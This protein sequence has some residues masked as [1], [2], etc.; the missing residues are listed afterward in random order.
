MYIPQNVYHYS[1]SSEYA[2]HTPRRVHFFGHFQLFWHKQSLC[3][4]IWRR[5]K[6][7]ILLQWFLLN[8][9]KL[10]SAEQLTDLFWNDM[11]EEAATRNLHV[12]IHYLRHLLEPDLP[13]RQ[14]STFLRRN[15]NNFYWFELDDTWWADIFDVH[16]LYTMAIK[17]DQEH[18]ASKAIFR[19]QK[20]VNYCSRG[21]LPGDCSEA[22]FSAHRNQYDS[23]Y[24]QSLVRLIQLFLER[25]ELEEVME[26]AYQALNLDHCCE[27][28]VKAIA[29]VHYQQK[30]YKEALS[31][32]DDFQ[33]QLRREF[34]VGPSQGIHKLREEM[35]Q[36][37][38]SMHALL[39][40]C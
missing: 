16:H 10:Y 9:G 31:R 36:R 26:Y 24:Y 22:A 2:Y 3:K 29:L 21:F 20:V 32:L 34:G 15:K 11:D 13:L 23:I 35:A 37:E 27:I 4:S 8:P 30:N 40:H 28:A 17:H 33:K 39:R 5:N 38:L 6:A 25:N 12:T 14:E 18:D 7:K 19:Y 1:H